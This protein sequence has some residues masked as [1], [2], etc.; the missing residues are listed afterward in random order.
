MRNTLDKLQQLKQESSNV[1]QAL[2]IEFDSS[3]IAGSIPTLL[4][5]EQDGFGK[6]VFL[7]SLSGETTSG[8]ISC[9]SLGIQ[10]NNEGNNIPFSSAIRVQSTTSDTPFS[11][12]GDGGRIAYTEDGVAIGIVI[13]G[14]NQASFCGWRRAPKLSQ[15]GTRPLC[16]P[17]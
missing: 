4:E 7:K 17:C 13:S 2:G 3:S 16:H 9:R 5:F 14:N 11:V 12:K 6:K 8:R 10:I 1:L 15:A